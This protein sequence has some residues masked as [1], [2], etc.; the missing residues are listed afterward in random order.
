M[1]DMQIVL[2][3]GWKFIKVDDHIKVHVLL[4]VDVQLFVRVN[5]DQKG[6]NVSL[7]KN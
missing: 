7:Q 4:A 5:G 1:E 2:H 3:V 6:S